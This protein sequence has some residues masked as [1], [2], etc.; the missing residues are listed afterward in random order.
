MRQSGLGVL[1]SALAAAVLFSAGG[2][3]PA[4]KAGDPGVTD[5]QV[6]IGQTLP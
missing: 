5:A 2:Y 3:P 6:K 1:G 4:A